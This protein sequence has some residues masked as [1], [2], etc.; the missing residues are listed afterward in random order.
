MAAEGAYVRAI[1]ILGYLLGRERDNFADPQGIRFR[2]YSLVRKLHD[3]FVQEYGS[4]ICR[5]IQ[6]KLVGRSYFLADPEE[7]KNFD[8][9]G[10]HDVHCPAVVGKAAR[11]LVEILSEEGL[12]TEKNQPA[13]RT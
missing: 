1:L 5:D 11:W 8:E 6:T 3:R 7:L 4:V 2:N 13:E 9:A 12:L 10:A